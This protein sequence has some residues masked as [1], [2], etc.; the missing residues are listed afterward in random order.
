MIQRRLPEERKT[1]R[2]AAG[3]LNVDSVGIA[4]IAVGSGALEVLLDRGQIEDWFGSTLICWLFVI[5]L[6]CLS[7]AV[8][9]ELRY[10]DPVID[11]RMLKDAKFCGGEYFLFHLRVRIVCEHDDDSADAAA[12]VWVS[13]N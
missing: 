5:G 2:N 7:A 9:W 8:F 11:F 6:G 4:L 1:V 12:T 13:R 10:P 3:K